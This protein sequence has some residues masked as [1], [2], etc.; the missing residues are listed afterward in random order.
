[1]AWALLVLAGLLEIVWALG[2]KH[3][4]GFSR[5]WPSVWTLAAMAARFTLLS[6]A[7]KTLPVGTGYAV[8]GDVLPEVHKIG[9]QDSAADRAHGHDERF[10]EV[11][12]FHGCVGIRRHLHQT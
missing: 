11:G 3:T 1:M 7:L 2:L 8:L 6:L 9:F 12:I 4:E 10:D 5:L